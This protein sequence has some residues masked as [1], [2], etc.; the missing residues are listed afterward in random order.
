LLSEELRE[1]DYDL[2]KTDGISVLEL[3]QIAIDRI[4]THGNLGKIITKEE[5]MVKVK[6]I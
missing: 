5:L 1:A 3:A 6:V 4:L 2:I